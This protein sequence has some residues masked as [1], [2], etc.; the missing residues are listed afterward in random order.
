MDTAKDGTD[1]S[2]L[3]ASSDTVAAEENE[4]LEMNDDENRPG[5]DPEFRRVKVYQLIGSRWEDK[6]TAF[7]FGDILDNGD[8]RIMAR[9]ERNYDDVILTTTVRNDVYQRQQETLI[10][11]TEPDGVDYALSFQDP[12]GCAEIWNFILEV[13]SG[14]A[15]SDD[16]P[17]SSSSPAYNP[18]SATAMKYLRTGQLPSPTMGAIEE[19]ERAL[20][21]LSRSPNVKERLC[22]LFISQEYIKQLINVMTD[23]EDLES[24]EQLH[25]LCSLMQTILMFGDHNL[26]EHILEDNI[27]LGV[28]GMLE[29]DPEFPEHKAN[30]RQFLSQCTTF[31]QPVPIR[32]LGVQR[33]IHHTYRLQF[34]K[35]VVLARVLDDSTFNVLNSCIIF[36]QIDIVNHIQQDQRFLA[37]IIRLYV[38]EDTLAEKKT[39]VNDHEPSSDSTAVD[40]TDG[41]LDDAK[42]G[43]DVAKQVNGEA[44]QNGRRTAGARI[45]H[46]LPL[47]ILSTQDAELRREVVFLIQQLCVMGKNIQLAARMSLF[48]CIVDRGILFPVQWALS[49]P[50]SDEASKPVISAGGEILTTLLDHD[51]NGVRNHVLKHIGAIER[52]KEAGNRGAD[53][54]ETLL[55]LVCRVVAQSR[56]LAVQSQIGEALKVWMDMP[57]ESGALAGEAS[58]LM[59]KDEPGTERFLDYFYKGCAKT[60]FAPITDLPD[61]RSVNGLIDIGPGTL[62]LTREE[63]NRYVYL[64][65]LLY[66]FTQHHNFRIMVH[67]MSQGLMTRVATLFKAKDKHLRH[68]AFRFFRLLLR[69]NNNN[70]HQ[71]LVKHDIFKPIVD[72][73][74]SESRRDNL[75]SGSCQDFFEHIRREN[76]K[77]IIEFIMTH[78]GDDIRKLAATPLGSHRFQM[79]IK[80]STDARSW[81]NV[82]AMDAEEE[83]WFNA[84]EEDDT[85]PAISHAYARGTDAA[86]PV[87]STSLKR[88]RRIMPNTSKGKPNG[89]LRSPS[90]GQ[91]AEYGDEDEEDQPVTLRRLPAAADDERMQQVAEEDEPPERARPESPSPGLMASMDE[92][93]PA[94]LGEKRRR[95]D[96]DDDDSLERLSKVK[97]ADAGK[98]APSGTSRS[99]KQGDDPPSGK[100]TMKLKLGRSATTSPSPMSPSP[101]GEPATKNGDKG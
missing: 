13:Q 11:W 56:D 28:V 32:D 90:L 67:I 52:A 36:N 45:F 71:Q 50:E 92:L 43:K 66:N 14:F 8:A 27:F 83:E 91:L 19:V 46:C 35:D 33:K 70:M 2:F 34:L 78:H 4:L 51:L 24:L 41:S 26:Y 15:P 60:L 77:A 68:S 1:D 48:R 57:S 63:T 39:E 61:W 29:Y 88:K 74:M 54:V 73:T 21:T 81:R 9:A 59:R 38:D 79:F 25:L 42:A 37:E 98:D 47:D 49:L 86:Q 99:V 85:I 69:M 62:P 93:G 55:E 17:I 87:A 3:D 95:D 75:L 64:C 5:D 23:L 6:G 89:P 84:D 65:D 31:H 94:R 72:L 18:E 96:D 58:H 22:E 80:R 44:Q 76:M 82:R 10:V 100:R 40:S 20:K 101:T 53:K 97:K 30:Y 7:C 16:V 12:D